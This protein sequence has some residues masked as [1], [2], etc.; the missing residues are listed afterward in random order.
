MIDDSSPGGTS[1]RR[2]R[3]YINRVGERHAK[4]DECASPA[5]QHWHAEAPSQLRSQMPV[6]QAQARHC[7]ATTQR[8]T[9]SHMDLTLSASPSNALSSSS[10]LSTP[11]QQEAMPPSPLSFGCGLGVI[12]SMLGSAV[13]NFIPLITPRCLS[14]GNDARS[15]FNFSNSPTAHNAYTAAPPGAT[16]VGAEGSNSLSST[17]DPSTSA[18]NRLACANGGVRLRQDPFASNHRT[19]VSGERQSVAAVPVQSSAYSHCSGSSTGT[20]SPPSFGLG[21]FE[22]DERS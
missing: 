18:N 17:C 20:W 15:V 22:V 9:M 1:P 4:H 19:L 6:H 10:I 7:L 8:T 14:M 11:V 2:Q 16:N 21:T 3:V 13:E 5:P 12:G